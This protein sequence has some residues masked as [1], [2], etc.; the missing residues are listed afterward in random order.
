MLT[1]INLIIFFLSETFKYI[2]KSDFFDILDADKTQT[3]KLFIAY[4]VFIYNIDLT[5]FPII[6]L[7]NTDKKRSCFNK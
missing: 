5:L 6:I 7:L 1:N 3:C 4:C 2:D